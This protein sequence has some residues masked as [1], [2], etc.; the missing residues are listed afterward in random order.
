MSMQFIYYGTLDE[1][2]DYFDHRLHSYAWTSVSLDDRRKAL[3]A[4]T[5]I[6]DTLNFKGK[7]ATVFV[8]PTSATLAE[9]MA[10]EAAQEREFPRGAD[11]D[12]PQEIRVASYEIAYS[13]LDGKDPEVELEN[14]GLISQGYASVRTTYN[15]AQVP[16]EHII[17]GI[18]N[19]AAWR[20]LRPFLRDDDKLV[21]SRVS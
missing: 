18:P 3:W 6:I 15:R 7:K 2:N 9:V 10:A 1:A 12:V 14:L 5:Q 21:L 4:A 19:A 17:N 13:L 8:L 16:I 20:L 11:I